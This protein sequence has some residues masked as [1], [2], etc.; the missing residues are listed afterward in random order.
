MLSVHPPTLKGCRRVVV[1][2]TTG[3]GKTTFAR[4]L[5]TRLGVPHVE[6]D[7][8]YWEPEWTPAPREVFR[9]RIERALDGDGWVA[10]GNYRGVR[11]IVW[12][13]AEA[14]VWLDYSLA[15]VLLRLIRRTARRLVTRQ[16]LWGTN[17]ER[18]QNHFLSRDSLFV[19]ALKTHPRHCREYPPLLRNAASAGTLTIRLRTP[20][21]ADAWLAA[22][23][24]CE[25]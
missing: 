16:T 22:V 5:A 8:L 4:Q 20:A 1:V 2:G 12:G 7:A 13:E 23:P 15:T 10:D 24:R 6:L 14:I 11:D 19:W 9:I 25:A 17:R 3:S 18:W 21:A